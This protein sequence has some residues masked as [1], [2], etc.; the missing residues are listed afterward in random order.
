MNSEQRIAL[1]RQHLTATLSPTRLEVVDESHLHRG[2]P[3]AKTGRGHFAITITAA[4]FAN[5][6]KVICHRMIY[7][8]LGDLM[9]TDIH[10]L[11]IKI[12]N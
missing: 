6:N 4:A 5:K 7:A 12:I 3:G 11:R 8:A 10:A 9:E 2:H 1:I